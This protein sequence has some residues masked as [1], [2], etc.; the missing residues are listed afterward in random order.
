MT[1][2]VMMMMMQA[3]RHQEKLDLAKAK[4]LDADG[5]VN[6][7][8]INEVRYITE[9][10]QVVGLPPASALF[11]SPLLNCSCCFFIHESIASFSGPH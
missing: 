4:K 3:D 9:Y 10:N 6:F 5:L 2:M 8:T 11:C 1:L 7:I